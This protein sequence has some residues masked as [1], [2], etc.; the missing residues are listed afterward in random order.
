[1]RFE[2]KDGDDTYTVDCW[3]GEVTFRC[4]VTGSK[5]FTTLDAC[6][7]SVK[8]KRLA[9]RKNFSNPSAFLYGRW[10]KGMETVTVTSLD[11]NDYAW[12]RHADGTRSKEPRAYLY[13]DAGV[14]NRAIERDRILT[15][16]IKDM[17]SNIK[18]WEPA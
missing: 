8:E 12:V 13:P 15:D 1:M 17:W 4:D 9:M 7:R 6:K 2:A 18:R 16:E 14:L 3:D 5:E 10:H 11:G